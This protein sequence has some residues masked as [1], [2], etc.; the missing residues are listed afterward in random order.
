MNANSPTNIE[1]NPVQKQNDSKKF[2]PKYAPT[3]V[4]KLSVEFNRTYGVAIHALRHQANLQTGDTLLVLST[5]C[6][7]GLAAIELGNLLG[8]R[9][10]AVCDGSEEC[11]MAWSA[12]AHVFIDSTKVSVEQA[13]FTLSEN[14][15][16]DIVFCAKP[17][18]KLSEIKP[19]LPTQASIL[20]A[21]EIP[22]D[23]APNKDYYA[24]M[25]T[26]YQQGLLLLQEGKNDP[27]SRAQK[28]ATIYNK[29][30]RSIN[31]ALKYAKQKVI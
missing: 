1:F 27:F 21:S 16:I 22:S 17:N 12:G 18:E 13:L 8:A 23:W 26:W 6:A 10:I 28:G 24:Q 4:C 3:S 29:G 20:V 9:V 5:N 11:E 31:G 7:V 2:S 25:L 19:I 15:Q 30:L 14:R